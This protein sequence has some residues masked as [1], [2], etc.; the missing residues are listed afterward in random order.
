[1]TM[2]VS[3]EPWPPVTGRPGIAQGRYG[4]NGNLELVACATDH[5]L[6]VGWWN[7]DDHESHAGTAVGCWS[8]ALHFAAGH[9]YES[10]AITQVRPGPDF[11]EVVAQTVDGQ[12]RRHVWTPE[13]G[14]LDHG[15]VA[16]GIRS[17]CGVLED[18]DGSLLV[19]TA[20]GD[21]VDV[22]RADHPAAYPRADFTVVDRYAVPGLVRSLDAVG[23]GT[24]L[25]LLLGYLDG[26]CELRCGSTRTI[27]ATEVTDARLAAGVR[28]RVAVLRTADGQALGVQLDD[29]DRTCA[30]GPADSVAVSP[31]ALTDH[32]WE[33]VTRR[34]PVLRHH[35]L[36][37]TLEIGSQ[38]PVE[39]RV[40]PTAGGPPVHRR[41]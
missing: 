6:W 20:A 13:T 19:A 14:F 1:M 23:H 32:S 5:G 24:H 31:V 34:G 12:L 22:R 11:L 3:T 16:T 38:D 35:V 30:L 18:T 28:G 33:I 29:G 10:A 8:G 39:A 7:A 9:Q 36:T 40:W 21:R 4:D 37:D 26:V 25:D 2:V 41:G 15:T 17:H 27:I